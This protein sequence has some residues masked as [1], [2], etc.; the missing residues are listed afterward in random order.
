M[1]VCPLSVYTGSVSPVLPST[2]PHLEAPRV[3]EVGSRWPVKCTLDGLFPASDAE[4]YLVLGD[5]RL[6]TSIAYHD[7]SVLAEAWIE[8]NEEEEG[9]TSL[10]CSVSLGMRSRRRER[11]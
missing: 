9:T 2:D 4:V 3:V 7:H 6:E 5:Q 1:S 10:K 11:A 8:G